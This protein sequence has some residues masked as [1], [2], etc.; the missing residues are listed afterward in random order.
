MAHKKGGGSTRNGRD[1]ESKRLG[2]KSYGGELISAG[3]IIVRQRGTEFHPGDNVGMGKD[4]TLF[5]KVDGT[6]QFLI[7]GANRRRVVTIVPA[8]A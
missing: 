2:V 6:V 8:A 7:K 1:S 4:H 5:A 3:S